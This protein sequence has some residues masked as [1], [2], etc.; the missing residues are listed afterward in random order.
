I[1]LI[2]GLVGQPALQPAALKMDEV[3]KQP[4]LP[5]PAVA[6][7]LGADTTESQAAAQQAAAP[8]TTQQASAA[9]PQSKKPAA[10][11]STASKKV[12]WEQKPRQWIYRLKGKG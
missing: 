7:Q 11:S 3:V 9:K 12:P 10:S 2:S 5:L 1:V 8:A 4:E 6:Q